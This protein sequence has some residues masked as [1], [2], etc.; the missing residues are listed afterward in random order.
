MMKLKF[1][2]GICLASGLLIGCNSTQSEMPL[3]ENKPAT[4]EQI[5]AMPPQAKQSAEAAA[6]AGNVQS[7]RMKEMAE[8]ERKA[9]GGG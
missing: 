3:P 6:Q 4:P 9:K 1:L 8:A 7:Q 2:A 5:D